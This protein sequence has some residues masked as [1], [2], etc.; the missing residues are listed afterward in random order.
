[1]HDPRPSVNW[2][3]GLTGSRYAN[4][5]PLARHREGEKYISQPTQFS[6]KLAM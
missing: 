5:D 2:S 6:Q 3:E 4:K 1:M